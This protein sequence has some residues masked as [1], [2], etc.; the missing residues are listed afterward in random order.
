MAKFSEAL[1]VAEEKAREAR[2]KIRRRERR[3]DEAKNASA[4]SGNKKRKIN[5]DRDRDIS[6][7][8]ALGMAS[9]SRGEVMMYDQRLFNQEKGMNSGFASTDDAYNIYDKHLFTAQSTPYR[10]KKDV[11]SDVYGGADE[12]QQLEKIIKTDRFKPDKAFAGT[13]ERTAP[14]DRPLE[15]E[16]A[17]PFGLDH[18]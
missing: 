11:D 17:D 12:Q 13:S 15:F 4:M 16:D 10:R 2:E 18:L 14:R 1:Y 6:E 7:K 9:T 3:L 5:R 8:V